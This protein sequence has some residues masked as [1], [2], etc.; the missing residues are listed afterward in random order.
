MRDGL[1]SF[2]RSWRDAR[3]VE[4]ERLEAFT[5]EDFEGLRHALAERK[6]AARSHYEELLELFTQ[7][8]RAA[9]AIVA[10]AASAEDATAYVARLCSASATSLVVKTKSMLSEEALRCPCFDDL[11]YPP[12][13][14][15]TFLSV[16]G[17]AQTLRRLLQL[18]HRA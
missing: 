2:Q 18:L 16:I 12:G 13:T 4:I 7:R 9:G 3:A 5:G 10:H 17:R 15:P 1:L 11:H 8:V 14:I 6:R